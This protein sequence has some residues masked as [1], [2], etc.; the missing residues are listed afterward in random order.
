MK[1]TLRKW[2]LK[3]FSTGQFRTKHGLNLVKFCEN[4]YGL[5][6]GGP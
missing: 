5:N 6:M 3:R 4:T 2:V 1:G